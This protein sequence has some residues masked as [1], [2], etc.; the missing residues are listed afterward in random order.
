MRERFITF[1]FERL[2]GANNSGTF[3]GFL[4]ASAEITEDEAKAF[5]APEVEAG[6]LEYGNSEMGT[7]FVRRPE[8]L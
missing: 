5:L 7:L 8:A 4:A 2:D 1:T 3:V 6:R